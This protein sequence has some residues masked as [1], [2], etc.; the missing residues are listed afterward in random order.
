MMLKEII[1]LPSI[2]L[3][4]LL[5]RTSLNDEMNTETAKISHTINRYFNENI[6]S[7]I[8]LIKN[9]GVTFSCYTNYESNEYGPYDYFFGQEVFSFDNVP[10]ELAKLIIPAG[11]FVRFTTNSGSMPNVII[12]AWQQIWKMTPNTLGGQ[13][14]YLVDFER[15]D[16]RARDHNNTIAQIYIGIK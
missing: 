5:V 1:E 4:G 2:M 16:E 8:P 15:Y 14:C 12:D 10:E 3:V 6:P 7:K 13:R 9:P 11:T